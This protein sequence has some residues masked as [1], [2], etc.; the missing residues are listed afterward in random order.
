VLSVSGISR[1]VTERKRVETERERL[2]AELEA[3]NAE[4]ERFTY[5]VSHDL[6][7]P[8]VTIGGFVGYLE[9]D[10][11]AGKTERVKADVNRINEA[12]EKMR[13]LLD[14]LLEMSRIGRL[15]NPPRHVAFG[16]IVK[17]ALR[18]VA[19]RLAE[20]GVEVVVAEELP[21]VYGDRVRLVEVVQNLVDNA[22]KFMGE[23][24][25]PRI[26]I[27]VKPGAEEPVFY[28]RD[29]GNGIEPRYHEEIFGLFKR[30][31]PYTEGTG[32][33]L[34]LVKRIV[35]VHGG[36]IWVQSAGQGQGSTFCFTLPV[37]EPK[38]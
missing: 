26:D 38:L 37:T 4:L 33:G 27:G 19:G 11:L 23:Q 22:V 15:V 29:N 25:Q 32:I 35:E 28:V 34:A 9:K 7:S 12:T 3:K 20:R 5:T 10:A 17:E 1:D 21:L 6:K 31:D 13:R 2:I 16:E 36:R 8:L 24:P 30:L 14:D 18:L